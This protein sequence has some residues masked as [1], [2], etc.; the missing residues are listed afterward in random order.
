MKLSKKIALIGFALLLLGTPTISN[1][2][3]EP[4]NAIENEPS[5]VKIYVS[6]SSVRIQ[7]AS[8]SVL[9]V[10]D[11]TGVCKASI[12]IDTSDKTIALNLSRGYYLLKVGNVVR[13]IAIR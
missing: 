3:S 11:V 1:A 5:D 7:N 8:G 13:K 6:G 10:Y 9:E 4:S 12:R 2:Q